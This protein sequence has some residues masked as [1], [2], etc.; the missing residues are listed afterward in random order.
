MEK[1]KVNKSNITYNAS[2]RQF[3][4]NDDEWPTLMKSYQTSVEKS[5]VPLA[6]ATPIQILKRNSHDNAVVVGGEDTKQHPVVDH[7]HRKNTTQHPVQALPHTNQY[8]SYEER[9]KKYYELRDKIFENEPEDPDADI[10]AEEGL[11]PQ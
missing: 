7:H 5:T 8:L 6:K 1:E 9:K 10:D 11:Q 2:Q 3:V 4:N